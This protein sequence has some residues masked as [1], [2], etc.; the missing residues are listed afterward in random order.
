VSYFSHS[1]DGHINDLH[2]EM[3]E[4]NL[5][6]DFWMVTMVKEA[7]SFGSP[8]TSLEVLLCLPILIR[9]ATEPMYSATAPVTATVFSLKY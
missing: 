7:F 9:L 1:I 4:R 8:F 2:K 3:H 5:S 6:S